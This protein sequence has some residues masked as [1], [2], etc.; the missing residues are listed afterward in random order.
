MFL[1]AIFIDYILDNFCLRFATLLIVVCSTSLD[2]LK[3]YEGLPLLN[4]LFQ[5]LT[6]CASKK[7]MPAQPQDY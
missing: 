1:A 4:R 2:R 3:G 6:E 7:R 5:T